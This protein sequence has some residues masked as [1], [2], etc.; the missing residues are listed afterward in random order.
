MRTKLKYLF[1]FL[2]FNNPMAASQENPVA[3]V[4]LLTC[5]PG[6]E[7]YSVYG[8]SALRVVIP[9]ND[10]DVVYNWE[11][12]F[13]RNLRKFAK[14]RLSYSLGIS[15]YDNFLRDYYLEK[16]WVVSEFNLRKMTLKGCSY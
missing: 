6:T 13:A 5:G 15:T 11:F 3:E 7:T 8:H 1:L 12:R 4:Y 16:Q 2:I 9:E 14:G 10:S